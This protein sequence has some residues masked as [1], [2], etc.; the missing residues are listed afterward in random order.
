MKKMFRIFAFVI[1]AATVQQAAAQSD[2]GDNGLIGKARAAAHEC[3]QP[4]Q[5]NWEINATVETTGICLVSGNLHRVTIYAG[6]KCPPNQ[7]CIMM[8]SQIIATVDFDCDGN[9]VHVECAN[10]EL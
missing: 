10:S 8:V 1:C 4:Y 9:V 6:P 5:G 3:I 7:P 2:A